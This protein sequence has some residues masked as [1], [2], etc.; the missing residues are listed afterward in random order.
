[1]PNIEIMKPAFMVPEHLKKPNDMKSKSFYSK[2][3]TSA[4]K[5]SNLN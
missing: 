5:S 4:H 2:F 3:E 1:M